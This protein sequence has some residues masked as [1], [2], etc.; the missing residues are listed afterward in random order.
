MSIENKVLKPPRTQQERSIETKKRLM[1]A[2][3]DALVEFGYGGLTTPDICKR[4][5]VSQGALFKHF[6]TKVDL[7]AAT[8]E[9]F[10]QQILVDYRKI[11]KKL[12]T[13]K[14]LINAGIQL[15]WNVFDSPKVIAS[16]DLH[17]AARTDPGLRSTLQPILEKHRTNTFLLAREL[18]PEIVK[19]NSHF[20][21]LIDIIVMTM[22]GIAVENLIFPNAKL[23]EERIAF[24]EH[25]LRQ[26]LVIPVETENP[27]GI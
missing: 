15:L 7:L 1:E 27:N 10:Y 25:L 13:E 3:I 5:G 21:K 2:T 16:M 22:Q 8:V 26:L 6:P 23:D 11:L 14:N 12:S 20:E 18:F 24:L 9:T 17:T 4:A 19:Q